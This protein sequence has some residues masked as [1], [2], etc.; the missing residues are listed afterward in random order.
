[1]KQNHV[2]LLLSPAAVARQQAHRVWKVHKRHGG[3]AEDLQLQSQPQD[4]ETVRRH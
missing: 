4:R 3:G 2:R 1:M